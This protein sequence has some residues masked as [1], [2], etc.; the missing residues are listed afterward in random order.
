MKF[1]MLNKMVKDYAYQLKEDAGYMGSYTDGGCENLLQRLANYKNR[2]V[3]ELDLRPSEFNKL[4]DIE[5][6]EPSEFSEVIKSYKMKLV[7]D[8]KL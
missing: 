7:R 3:V 8:I 6:G 2:F 4:D 1:S 5:V